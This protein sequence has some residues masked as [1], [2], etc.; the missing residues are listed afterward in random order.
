[1]SKLAHSNDEAMFDIELKERGIA[2][3]IPAVEPL[4]EHEINQVWYKEKGATCKYKARFI[5]ENGK[6]LCKAHLIGE[7]I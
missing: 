6:K 2:R 1:M 7:E 3:I 5:N 4:C